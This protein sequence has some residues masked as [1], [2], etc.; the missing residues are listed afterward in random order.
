MSTHVSGKR[1]LRAELA[2][3]TGCNHETIRYYENINLLPDPPRTVTGY[4]VYDE[5]HVLRLRFILRGRDLGFDI[6]EI[7]GLLALIDGGLGTCSEFKKRTEKHLADVRAR[8]RD[9]KRIEGVLSAAA[10][11]CTGKKVPECP[12]LDALSS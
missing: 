7:R 8:I 2:A 6:D 5:S 9:L 1:L 4:R 3:R 12:V 11:K 10:K